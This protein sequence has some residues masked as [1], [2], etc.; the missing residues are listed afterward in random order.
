MT[1]LI[2]R[3]LTE[4]T[5]IAEHFYR[6][7]M[8]PDLASEAQAVVKIL[9]GQEIGIGPFE[10]MRGIDVIKGKTA[11]SAGLIGARI[12]ASGRYDYS[13][14][15]LD[16]QGCEIRFFDQG[17]PLTPHSIFERVDAERAGLLGRDMYSKFPRNMY[18]ARALSNGARWHCPDVFGGAVYTPDELKSTD[19]PVTESLPPITSAP[20]ENP[21]LHR[22]EGTDNYDGKLRAKYIADMTTET[23]KKLLS[24]KHVS[25]LTPADK[26][27]VAQ[28]LD[29]PDL[30][31]TALS[32][33]HTEYEHWSQESDTN[34]TDNN[35]SHGFNQEY[36]S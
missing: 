15:R 24:A 33:I 6:S 20:A 3:P 19:Y 14:I 10:A 2:I 27:A 22:F 28:A 7:G 31:E 32:I 23:L 4:I 13:I 9:A 30:R 8:F 17:Q 36:N 34:P 1:T 5:A 29:H 12:K 25:K 21:F 18:F 26:I 16:D 35:E 11:L